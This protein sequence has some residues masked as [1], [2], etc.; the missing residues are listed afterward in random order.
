MSPSRP[1]LTT[2]TLVTTRKPRIIHSRKK[3]F[4]GRSGSRWM[5]RKMSGSAISTIEPSM[6][7]IS[8]PSVVM[9]SA[10][11]CWRSVVLVPV[12]ARPVTTGAAVAV[13]LAMPLLP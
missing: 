10:I 11:H 2:S 12:R 1:K 6:V 7:A 9:N 5:P 3:V 8:M 13:L 4:E